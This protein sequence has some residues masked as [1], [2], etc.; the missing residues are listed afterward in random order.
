MAEN[1]IFYFSGTGNCLDIARNIAKGIGGAKL[2]RIRDK[3]TVKSAPEADKVGFVFPCY[4][5]GAPDDVLKFAS[6]VKINP[7]AYTFGIVSCAAYAGTGLAKLNRIIPLNYWGVISHHCSCIWLFPHDMMLPRLTIGEAQARSADLAEKM[8]KDISDGKNKNRKP[9]LNIL[10][11]FENMGWSMA[12]QKK[13]A[14]FAVSDSCVACGQCVKLCPRG[15]IRIE[16]NKAVIGDNCAQCLSCLQFCP[17]KAISIGSIT[18]KREHYH[19][20]HVSAD[21]LING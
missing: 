21:D 3:M 19:N 17:Q 10:N 11:V 18:D 12:A 9:P 13:I 16:D 15:N 7:R 6:R 8:A 4:G 20:P 5:G 2:V 14:E 1:I